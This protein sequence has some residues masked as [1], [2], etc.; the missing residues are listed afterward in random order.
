M[1]DNRHGIG[2]YRWADGKIYKGS[3]ANDDRNGMGLLWFPDGDLYQGNYKDSKR[4]GLQI[5]H[6]KATGNTVDAEYQDD[7]E[8]GL[9][10]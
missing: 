9:F 8:E 3:W 2:E 4:D 5:I 10:A 6:L 1:K 7:L